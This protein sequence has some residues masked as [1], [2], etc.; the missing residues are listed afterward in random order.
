MP[1]DRTTI[2]HS[3]RVMLVVYPVF[4]SLVGLS[5]LLGSPERTSSPSFDVVRNIMPMTHWGAVFLGLAALMVGAL[6]THRRDRMVLALKLS[7]AAYSIWAAGFAA[8]LL[9]FHHWPPLNDGVSFNAIWLW[10]FVAFAHTASL[11]SLLKDR[12]VPR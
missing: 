10:A 2:T 9:N 1:L 4:A 8:S 7:R 6:I 3:S 5:Y 11:Q 12:P